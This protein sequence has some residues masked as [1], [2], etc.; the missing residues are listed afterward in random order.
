MGQALRLT[1]LLQ[2]M[3]MDLPV[4]ARSAAGYLLS[5]ILVGGT[6]VET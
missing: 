4:L 6:F 5:G 1:H 3:G 2:A